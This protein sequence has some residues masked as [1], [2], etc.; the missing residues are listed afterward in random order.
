VIL[1]DVQN[2]DGM[3]GRMLFVWRKAE[4]GTQK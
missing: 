2:E 1:L 3:F 4:D